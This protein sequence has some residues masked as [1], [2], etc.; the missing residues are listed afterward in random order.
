MCGRL[1]QDVEL[2]AAPRL[3][4]LHKSVGDVLR[5]LMFE[6]KLSPAQRRKVEKQ[7]LIDGEELADILKGEVEKARASGHTLLLDGVPRN[8]EQL[9]VFDAKVRAGLLSFPMQTALTCDNV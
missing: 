8:L 9:R 5:G 1:V 6:G 4:V 3:C 2:N 7:E